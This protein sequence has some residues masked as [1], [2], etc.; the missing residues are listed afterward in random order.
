MMPEVQRE[1]LP[2][3]SEK[4]RPEAHRF[5]LTSANLVQSEA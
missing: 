1:D 5:R 4:R 2:G 3:R